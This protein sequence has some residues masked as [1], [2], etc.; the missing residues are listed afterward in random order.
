MGWGEVKECLRA[1]HEAS[2][3]FLGKAVLI[4]GAACWFYRV[5]LQNAKDRDFAEGPGPEGA[6]ES[7]LSKDV[8]F[9]G[10]FRGDAIGMLPSLVARDEWGNQFLAVNG[11]R[12]GFAQVG[13]TF[14]PEEVFGRAR[15]G[16]F[17]GGRGGDAVRFLVIDPVM[18]YREKLV[19]AARRNQR[20]D[21]VHL[22]MLAQLLRWEF[23]ASCERYVE[24]EDAGIVERQ[25]E[26]AFLLDV[27]R[28]ALEI[29]QGEAVQERLRRLKGRDSGGAEYLR[30]LFVDGD[31]GGRV[32][33]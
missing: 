28:R 6:A 29:T 23:V 17:G 9:T 14:D 31:G 15:I 30:R 5:Q 2:P 33:R 10:V 22:A 32:G 12:L 25:R 3:D 19:L 26:L 21:H 1:L 24:R 20:N 4:G 7:W 16:E 18:L 13:V 27:K 8:D 11:V